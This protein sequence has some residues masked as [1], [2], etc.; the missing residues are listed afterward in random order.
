MTGCKQG[1]GLSLGVKEGMVYHW[2]QTGKWFV[3]GCKGG[4]G[5]QLGANREMVCPWVQTTQQ[6]N[7]ATV[8][9]WMLV[10][11]NQG[12]GLSL[13]ANVYQVIFNQKKEMID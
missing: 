2:V 11:C 8:C 12:N 9:L 4:N 10:G 6:L 3:P 5:L 7:R 1:N 13:D